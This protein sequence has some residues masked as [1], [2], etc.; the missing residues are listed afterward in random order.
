M[1]LLGS[2]GG[3]GHTEHVGSD[4]TLRVALTEFRMNPQSATVSAGQLTIIVHNFGR[5]T[6]NLALSHGGQSAAATKPIAPGESAQLTVTLVPGTYVM[7]STIL[8]DEA[9][10]Q[11]G[12]LRVLRSRSTRARA[13]TRSLSPAPASK[14]LAPTTSRSSSHGGNQRGPAPGPVFMLFGAAHV[15]RR[16]RRMRRRG[17]RACAPAIKL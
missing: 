11:Y 7:A 9:L 3:C 6:H 4:R 5:L 14:T 16:R 12:T 1:L 13:E 2:T 17:R 10:G 15:P 8:D